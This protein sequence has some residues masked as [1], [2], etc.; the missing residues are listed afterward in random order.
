MDVQSTYKEGRITL[1][2]QA[3]QDGYFTSLR[4]AANAY[5]IPASTLRYRVNGGRARRG[6]RAVNTKL[7]TTE[8]EALVKWILSMEERGLPVRSSSIQQMA[9]LLLQKRSIADRENHLTVGKNWVYT[10]IQRYTS[11]RSKY[12]R[13]YNY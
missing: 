5:D 4:A 7:S 12:N 2:L 8:E 9:N 13:K 11:L 6:L 1:A 3:Y 10:F